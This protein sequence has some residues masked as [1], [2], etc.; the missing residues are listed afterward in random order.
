VVGYVDLLANFYELSEDQLGKVLDGLMR[1][2]LVEVRK[3][4]QKGLLLYLEGSSKGRTGVSHCKGPSVAQ[5]LTLGGQR[6][7]GG[8]A[9]QA[10]KAVITL[11][12]LPGWQRGKMMHGL[13]A[14]GLV[15]G[16][17]GG[18]G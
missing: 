8:G 9:L 17:I 7:R 15:R 18:E 11:G 14:D 12:C 1:E 6:A 10:D 2:G 3:I 4:G 16:P 13:I 5:E